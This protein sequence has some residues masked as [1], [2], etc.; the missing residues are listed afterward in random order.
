MVATL[1]TTAAAAPAVSKPGTHAQSPAAP[2]ASQRAAKYAVTA[3]A[4]ATKPVMTA[5]PCQ[6][7]GV[8]L[9]AKKWKLHVAIPAVGVRRPRQ[10]SAQRTVVTANW[11]ATRTATMATPLMTTDVAAIAQ[12]RLDGP[13]TTPTADRQAAA[14]YAVT[15]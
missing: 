7:M 10:I 12:R 14:K 9:C 8:L 5:T 13:A 2:A 4:L 15:A 3:N 11:P 1:M 6:A